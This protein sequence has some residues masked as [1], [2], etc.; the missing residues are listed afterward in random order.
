[1][2]SGAVCDATRRGRADRDVADSQSSRTY[3]GHII[4]VAGN[5]RHRCCEPCNG[6]PNRFH[7]RLQARPK[8]FNS[9]IHLSPVFAGVASSQASAASCECALAHTLNDHQ[10]VQVA[11]GFGPWIIVP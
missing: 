8:D 1:M 3:S 7:Q 6:P 9:D 10:P 5:A 11:V 4:A 2:A